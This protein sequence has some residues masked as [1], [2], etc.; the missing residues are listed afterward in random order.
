MIINVKVFRNSVIVSFLS[1]AFLKSF[2]A[3][4]VFSDQGFARRFK[5]PLCSDFL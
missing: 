1:F 3:S 2:S 4:F 5:K